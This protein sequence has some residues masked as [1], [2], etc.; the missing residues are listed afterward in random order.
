MKLG[1]EK[2][3]KT[4][5]QK[6]KISAP[7]YID[8]NVE[9]QELSLTDVQSRNRQHALESNLAGSTKSIHPVSSSF[10]LTVRGNL[11]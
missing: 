2:K 8:L 6:S 10:L 5:R 9:K 1:S 3:R 7:P 11:T 4:N